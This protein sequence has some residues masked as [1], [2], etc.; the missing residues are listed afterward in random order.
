MNLTELWSHA[1]ELELQGRQEAQ[2][3]PGWTVGDVLSSM[4]RCLPSSLSTSP[5]ITGT[6]FFPLQA[7]SI[8][9]IYI[10]GRGGHGFEISTSTPTC[11]TMARTIAETSE[12]D[13]SIFKQKPTWISCV[14]Q[15]KIN[16]THLSR[17]NNVLTQ[18]R[19]PIRSLP[20]PW[21]V[22]TAGKLLIGYNLSVLWDSVRHCG[23]KRFSK[24]AS[25]T[26]KERWAGQSLGQTSAIR[27]CAPSALC[28]F[29]HQEG[30]WTAMHHTKQWDK[31]LIDFIW[32][33]KPH[34]LR[35]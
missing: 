2:S 16:T 14:N 30:S 23:Q 10:Q 22:P 27:F 25:W 6:S 17:R 1:V 5:H 24:I 31:M 7:L 35:K 9:Y 28:N 26:F 34:Y 29:C 33:N 3:L 32:K 20:A 11:T 19:H 15:S 13:T 12:D 18:P 4:P 8:M 21:V